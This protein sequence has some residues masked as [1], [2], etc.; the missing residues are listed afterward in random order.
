MGLDLWL[1]FAYS[2]KNQ[3]KRLLC[4]SRERKDKVHPYKNH[5]DYFFSNQGCL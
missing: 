2:H 1:M 4:G 5:R 3:N